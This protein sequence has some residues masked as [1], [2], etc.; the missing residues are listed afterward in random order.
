MKIIPKSMLIK[1]TKLKKVRNL[2]TLRKV[3]TFFIKVYTNLYF[4]VAVLSKISKIFLQQ[5]WN[6]NW[7]WQW[8]W[9]WIVFVVW[10]TDERRL[11]LFSAGPI[12][13]DPHHRESPT[14]REQGLNLPQNLSSGLVEESCAVVITIT[15]RQHSTSYPYK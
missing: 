13:R 6:V 4:L 8:W 15:P 12:V 9:W 2:R 1:M 5:A 10:L 11:A 14:R 7:W 3:R